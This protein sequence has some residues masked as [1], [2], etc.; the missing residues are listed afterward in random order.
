MAALKRGMY[1]GVYNIPA[2]LVQAGREII[3]DVFTESCDKIWITGDLPTPW[4]QLMII[5][6]PKKGNL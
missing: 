5:M 3:I 4:T 6:L 2:E 1:S